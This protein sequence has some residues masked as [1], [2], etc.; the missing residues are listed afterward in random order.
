MRRITCTIFI[1]IDETKWYGGDGENNSAHS[2]LRDSL[3]MLKKVNW[4]VKYITAMTQ[5]VVP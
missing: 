2:C 1:F 3:L 5:H 4:V